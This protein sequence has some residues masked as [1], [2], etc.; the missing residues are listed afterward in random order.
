M[1]GLLDILQKRRP[2]G[3]LEPQLLSNEAQQVQ[4]ETWEKEDIAPWTPDERL[5]VGIGGERGVADFNQVIANI[6]AASNADLAGRG[7]EGYRPLLHGIMLPF[8]KSVEGLGFQEDP[9][10]LMDLFK[11]YMTPE[12]Y[13]YFAERQHSRFFK[14]LT[15]PNLSPLSSGFMRALRDDPSRWN[16][17][18]EWMNR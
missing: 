12:Q 8:L 6:A 18:G 1:V 9:Q 17:L 5:A 7:T 11:R 3:L 15:R 2:M 13:K 4:Q 14:F 10:A 16:I